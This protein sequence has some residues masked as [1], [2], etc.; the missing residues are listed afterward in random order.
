M[1]YT[2]ELKSYIDEEMKVIESLNLSEVSN[3]MNILEETRRN[4]GRIVETE[5]A[6]LQLH[7]LFVILT[8]V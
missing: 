5:V 8:K 7:I 1:D 6:R 3:V 2:K 4:H